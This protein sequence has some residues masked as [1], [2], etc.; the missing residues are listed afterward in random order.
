MSYIC[1]YYAI[2]H[3]LRARHVHTYRRAMG[4]L[5]VFWAVAFILVLP[6]LVIQRLEPFIRHQPNETPPIRLAMVC[7]EFFR[8]FAL[9]AA[10]TIIFYLVLY[11]IPVIVMFATYGKIAYTLW[12]REPIGEIAEGSRDR[13]MS[14]KKRVVRMLVVIVVLFAI[15]WFPFFTGHVY[16]LFHDSSESFRITMA[17]LQ[18][19]GY[20]NSCTN[21]I[22]YCFMNQSFRQNYLKYLPFRSRRSG[23]FTSGYSMD[24]DRT[25]G[26]FETTNN[27]I[28]MDESKNGNRYEVINQTSKL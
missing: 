10:Y 24:N 26:K 16:L 25:T 12:V 8:E 13:R 6:Q 7:T 27:T 20:S 19:F 14:E 9:S 5:I 18:L 3:P 28:L 23:T 1:R 11:L 21:P 2:C 17:I 22:V 15:S 4:I